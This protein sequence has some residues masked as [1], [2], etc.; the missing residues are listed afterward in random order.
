MTARAPA[1][2][3][4]TLIGVGAL[5]AFQNGGVLIFATVGVHGMRQSAFDLLLLRH[6]KCCWSLSIGRR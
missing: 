3:L 6:Q 1:S 5:G 2:L 4:Q